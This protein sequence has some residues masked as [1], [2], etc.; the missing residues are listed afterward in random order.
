MA[1]LPRLPSAISRSPNPP[2]VDGRVCVRVY[3]CEGAGPQD[4]VCVGGDVLG[5]V[6][7]GRCIHARLVGAC[8]RLPIR[9]PFP[10]H[11]FRRQTKALSRTRATCERTG[12]GPPSASRA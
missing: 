3:V 4:R 8:S 9:P 6:I 2:P 12:V 10:P 1:D 7:T 5:K 11:D